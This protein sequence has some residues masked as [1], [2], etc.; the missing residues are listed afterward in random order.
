MSSTRTLNGLVPWR[1]HL[2][3]RVV[4]RQFWLNMYLSIIEHLTPGED[5]LV[6]ED[7]WDD[8][9]WDTSDGSIRE[10]SAAVN[11]GVEV[12]EWPQDEQTLARL[13]HRGLPVVLPVPD[14]P[15]D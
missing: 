7:G 5:V 15:D 4:D 3:G 9:G 11:C 14:C 10:R 1:G 6:L 12:F 13:A 8:Q 2:R